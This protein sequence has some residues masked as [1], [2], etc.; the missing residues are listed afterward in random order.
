MTHFTN[1]ADAAEAGFTIEHRPDE[2]RFVVVTDDRVIGYAHYTL[3]DI[4]DEAGSITFDGTVV[5]PAHR[6]AGL[7]RILVQ[8]ALG[9]DIVRGREVR[10][11]CWYV[12]QH[13]ERNPV[14]LAEGAR[15]GA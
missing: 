12:A 8:R 2:S 11:T 5:N 14:D 13:I 7:A 9:D 6:G 4:P 10:A 15:Y 1:E 3:G